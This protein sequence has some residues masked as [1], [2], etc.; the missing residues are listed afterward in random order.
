M[1]TLFNKIST[2][3]LRA[4]KKRQQKQRLQRNTW[5]PME[6]CPIN[7]KVLFKMGGIVYTGLCKVVLGENVYIWYM[8][9]NATQGDVYESALNSD[10]REI[11]L[12][13]EYAGE[14]Q[15]KPSPLDWKRGFKDKPSA[16]AYLPQDSEGV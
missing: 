12:M 7:T 14:P 6:S 5:K 1:K 8:H 11:R 10:G 9:I 16:W 3:K 2:Y 4:D 13:L 15:Y